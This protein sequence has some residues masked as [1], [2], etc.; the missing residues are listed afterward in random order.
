MES[1]ILSE[2]MALQK[3]LNNNRLSKALLNAVCKATGVMCQNWIM[4]AGKINGKA[5]ASNSEKLIATA[6][7]EKAFKWLK[8]CGLN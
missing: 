7:N 8:D 3:Y 4:S 2:Q 5:T 6:S 1:T